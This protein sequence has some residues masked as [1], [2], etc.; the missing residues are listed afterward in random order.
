[1]SSHNCPNCG[2]ALSVQFKHARMMTC[3]AC[4]TTLYLKDDAFL[5][6]GSAGEMHDGP[7]LIS[8]GD[9]VKLN[10]TWFDIL[11][12][13][14][15]DY[16]PGW[17]DEF[18]AIDSSGNGAWISVDEGE[19]IL[20]RPV[21]ETLSGAPKAA[22]RLGQVFNVNG[23]MYRVTERDE[24]TCIALRGEFPDMLT[25]GEKHK[26]INARNEHADILSGEFSADEIKWFIGQWID[27]FEVDVETYT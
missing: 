25:I 3:D 21:A 10:N 14:R 9:R 12:H 19:V 17:W 18:Y 15:F 11:G 2:N 4:D 8:L 16:G 26:F 23:Y 22:P 24:A 13:V 5:N 1:M 27:P 20:Q 6:A 7:M